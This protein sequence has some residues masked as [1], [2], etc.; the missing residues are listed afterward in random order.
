[1]LIVNG[2]NPL[3]VKRTAKKRSNHSMIVCALYELRNRHH[4][5]GDTEEDCAR[6]NAIHWELDFFFHPQYTPRYWMK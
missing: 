6:N 1:M 2:I 5:F 3:N 4:I